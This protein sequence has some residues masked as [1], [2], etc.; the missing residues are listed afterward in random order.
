MEPRIVSRPAFTVAGLVHH[1]IVDGEKLGALWGKFFARK[2]ELK[3]EVEPDRT[4][5][6]MANYDE[7]SNEF[8]YIAASQVESCEDLPAGFL[9][10]EVPAAEWAVFTTT[11]PDLPQT[12]PY[13]Y[14]TW[15]PQSGYQHAPAPEFELYGETFDPSDPASQFEIYIPVVK[16]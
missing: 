2:A 9:S 6:V 4:Y 10:L 11:M 8:D 1:G 3:H 14:S 15:L 7:A 12:Y 5:G 13:I 16:A